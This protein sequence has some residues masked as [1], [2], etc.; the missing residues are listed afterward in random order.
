MSRPFKRESGKFGP[1][2]QNQHV[3][4]ALLAIDAS[5]EGLR[6][7]AM[8]VGARKCIFQPRLRASQ[9]SSDPVS[10]IVGPP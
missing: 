5:P 4:I 9:V 7:F 6:T 8:A 3:E 1:G 2:V 10:M